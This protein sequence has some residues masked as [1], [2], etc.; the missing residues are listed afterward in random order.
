MRG[1]VR[2]L[3]A[4][5]AG[6]PILLSAVP[7]VSAQVDCPRQKVR[8]NSD[9]TSDVIC[10]GSNQ[11]ATPGANRPGGGS[12]AG[13]PRVAVPDVIGVLGFGNDPA[14]GLCFQPSG[15]TIPTAEYNAPANSAGIDPVRRTA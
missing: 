3:V 1:V 9:G 13:R 4:V 15:Q 12:A 8:E 7:E 10:S 2:I 11:R 5:L 14:T 6:V